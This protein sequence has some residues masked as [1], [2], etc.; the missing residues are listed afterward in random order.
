[1]QSFQKKVLEKME[2]LEAKTRL[3][4]IKLLNGNVNNKGNNGGGGDLSQY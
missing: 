3:L 2:N 4:E 1:M